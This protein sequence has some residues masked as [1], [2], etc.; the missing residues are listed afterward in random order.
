MVYAL[1]DST[2]KVHWNVATD[3]PLVFPSLVVKH[4]MD[5]LVIPPYRG[6]GVK[7]I[8]NSYTRTIWQCSVKYRI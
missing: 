5:N 2:C 7:I 6:H 1:A 3:K 4:N 8:R